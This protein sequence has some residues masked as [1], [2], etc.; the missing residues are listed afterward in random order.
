MYQ[1]SMNLYNIHDKSLSTF[2]KSVGFINELANTVNIINFTKM[3]LFCGYEC[4]Y[5][6]VGTYDNSIF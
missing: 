2:L 1:T 4:I 3:C 6:Y 5:M